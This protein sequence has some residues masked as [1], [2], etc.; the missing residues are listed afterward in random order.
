MVSGIFPL[1]YGGDIK[2]KTE[3]GVVCH[4]CRSILESETD[5]DQHGICWDCVKFIDK[6]ERNHKRMVK[7]L[8][9]QEQKKKGGAL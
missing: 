4:F 9:E 2:M 5:L 8:K 3:A 7:F 6:S 1:Y